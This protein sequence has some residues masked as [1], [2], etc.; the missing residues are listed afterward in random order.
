MSFTYD[1]YLE[2]VMVFRYLY[3]FVLI[4]NRTW[5]KRVS[6]WPVVSGMSSNGRIT[7]VK[8]RIYPGPYTNYNTIYTQVTLRMFLTKCGL[9]STLYAIKFQSTHQPT[10]Q[11]LQLIMLI[12]HRSIYRYNSTVGDYYK[13]G[14]Y[15]SFNWGSSWWRHQIETFSA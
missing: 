7:Y 9:W 11:L 8:Y 4:A 15:N 5:D 10:C 6:L 1:F 2:N 14:V 3:S 13:P 12:F